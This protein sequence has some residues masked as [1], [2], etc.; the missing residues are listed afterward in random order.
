MLKK[1][2]YF[3]LGL[4]SLLY[5]NFDELV[6]AGEE[7][8]KELIDADIPIEET[9]EIETVVSVETVTEGVDNVTDATGVD[10]LTAINGIGPMKGERI[11]R[12]DGK[13]PFERTF[14]HP[15]SCS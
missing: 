12:T 1:F 7:R 14:S 9:V 11:A 4:A 6:R 3:G 8:Y 5:E 10:D 13:N 15:L 2:F